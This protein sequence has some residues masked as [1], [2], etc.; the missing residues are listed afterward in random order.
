MLHFADHG[1]FVTVLQISPNSRAMNAARLAFPIKQRLALPVMQAAKDLRLLQ[2]M[3]RRLLAALHFV[4][5]QRFLGGWG[6][7]GRRLWT[8]SL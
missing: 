2:V 3:F 8:N 1:N 7:L 6:L 5:W 4:L